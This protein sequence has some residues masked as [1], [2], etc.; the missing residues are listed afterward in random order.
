VEKEM[1]DIKESSMSAG[2]LILLALVASPGPSLAE[3]AKVTYPLVII[4][5]NNGV[6]HFAYLNRIDAE[7]TAT[8]MTPNGQFATVS[9]G[10]VIARAGVPVEGSCAGKTLEELRTAGQTLSIKE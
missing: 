1:P 10:G 9:A 6:S 8:Y 7:G 4:C 3:E 5:K 2:I